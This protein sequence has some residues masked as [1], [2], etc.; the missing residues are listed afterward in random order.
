MNKKIFVLSVFI[1]A[2]GLFAGTEVAQ[3]SLSSLTP[4]EE[5]GKRLFF[6]K[7]LSTPPGQECAACHAPNVGMTGPDEE[8]NKK[9]GIYEG[10]VKGRF[11]NRKPPAVGQDLKVP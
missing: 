11:G 3:K 10:A 7:N 5:L 8:I 9:G 1:L 6:D 2:L 4:L